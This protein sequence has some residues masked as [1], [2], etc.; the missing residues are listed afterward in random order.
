MSYE[1]VMKLAREHPRSKGTIE[2][3]W[4][5]VVRGCYEEAKSHGG[6]R[7]A[8]SWVYKRQDVGWFPS[9]RMLDEKYGILRKV[10][11]TSKHT[12]YVMPDMDGVARALQELRAIPVISH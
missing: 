5:K 7:F 3:D 6:N 1:G 10:A 11:Q 8:G 2:V 9:L 12:F 4:L